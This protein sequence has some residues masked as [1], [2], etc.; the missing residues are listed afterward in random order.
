MTI[1]DLRSAIRRLD[2]DPTDFMGFEGDVRH[3]MEEHV[4]GSERGEGAIPMLVL[5]SLE[6]YRDGKVTR[7]GDTLQAILSNDL[8][9]VVRADDEVFGSIRTIYRWIYQNIESRAWGTQHK[10]ARWLDMAKEES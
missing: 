6:Q 3:V 2:R 8:G 5:I 4:E 7:L 10:V 9:A 1:E